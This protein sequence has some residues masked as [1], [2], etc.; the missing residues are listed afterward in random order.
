V[1][2]SHSRDDGDDLVHE[3]DAARLARVE[4]LAG[5]RVAS[6]LTD[7]D[8][9]GQLGMMMLAIKPRRVSEMEKIASSAAMATSQAATKPVPPPKHPPWTIA[10]VGTESR[11]SR[12]TASAVSL[13]TRRFSAGEAAAR[14][15]GGVE[16]RAGRPRRATLDQAALTSIV[17]DVATRG[18]G[19]LTSSTPFAHFASTWAASTPSGRS[20]LR[21]KA[22]YS[23]SRTK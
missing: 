6:Q 4:A 23:T 13:E 10:M 14:S 17:L 3:A 16:A 20:K 9:I 1:Q 21:W 7:T 19:T 5:E 15:Q 18:A 22:P 2:P 11:S 8:G 12:R